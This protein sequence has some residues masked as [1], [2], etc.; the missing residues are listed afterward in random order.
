MKHGYPSFEHNSLNTM[1][2]GVQM[3]MKPEWIS[4]HGGFFTPGGDPLWEC[5]NCREKS[6]HVYGIETSNNKSSRCPVCGMELKYPYENK[7]R[8]IYGITER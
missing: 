5:P 1:T 8:K 7:R 4:V 2:G 3:R 6:R